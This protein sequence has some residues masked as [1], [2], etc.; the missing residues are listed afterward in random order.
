MK[1][2]KQAIVSSFAHE[3]TF[4]TILYN[5]FDIHLSEFMEIPCVSNCDTVL[6]TE[7]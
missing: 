5:Y 2:E 3:L 7:L 4:A 6:N 1:A